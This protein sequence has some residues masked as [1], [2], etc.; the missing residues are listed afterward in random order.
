MR[1]NKIFSGLL[2]FTVVLLVAS[3]CKKA[4][5]PDPLGDRGQTIVKFLDGLADTAS[6]YSS[7]YKLINLDL[8]PTPQVLDMVDI[9]RD[10]A[11][12]VDLNK[13]MTVTVKQDPGAASAYNPAFI[14][15]PDGSYTVD[16]STPLVGNEYTVTLK[17]GE[18]SK[19]IYI[20]LNNAAALDLNSQ[21]ALGFTITSADSDGKL[22]ALESSIVVELGV[23]NPWDGV[24]TVS[25]NFQGHPNACL[26]GTFFT[27]ANDGGPNRE[28]QLIT[29]GSRIVKRNLPGAVA[30]S[31]AVWNSCTSILTYFTA[32]IPRYQINS[33]NTVTI[34][35][36]PGAAVVWNNYGSTYSPITKSFNLRYGYNGSRIINETFRY[37]R[38]R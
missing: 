26:L 36:G 28:I 13:T 24:Y 9:R 29:V 14:A 1:H 31:L 25:G 17:P 4:A 22:A 32:V 23:K 12:N 7:G 5:S 10:L 35:D 37:V 21:Y 2:L 15:L 8:V 34:L 6:G 20:T 27:G 19:R 16:G 18:I 33:D 30:E 38:P 3:A 11:N